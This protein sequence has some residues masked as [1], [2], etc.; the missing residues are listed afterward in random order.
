MHPYLSES[1]FSHLISVKNTFVCLFHTTSG[2]LKL[3]SM[4]T[5]S[6]GVFLA[7]KS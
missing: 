2:V 3:L 5:N 4:G 6:L 1:D 7:L